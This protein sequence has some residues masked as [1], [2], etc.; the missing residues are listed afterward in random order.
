MRI[1]ITGAN[2]FVGSYIVSELLEIGYEV[3][4]SSRQG[5]SSSFGTKKNFRFVQVDI[6]DPYSLHDA[7]E[8]V[9]PDV[10]VHCAA[11]SKPDEC[12]INQAAAFDTNVF[13][14]VQ[15]LLNAEAYKSFFIHLSTDFIFNGKTGMHKEDDMPDPISYYGKTKLQAEEAVMEYEYDWAIVRT[16]FV[17]GKPIFGR[18][19]F[20]SMIEKKLRNNEPFK[21][22]NDQ[23]RT[24]T[25]ALDLA[26]GIATLIEKRATGVYHLCGKDVLSPYDMAI[27]TAKYLNIKEHQLTPVTTKA[28]QELA[29]RPLKSGLCIG[30][31]S[32]DLGFEPMSFKEGLKQTLD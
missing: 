1:L 29:E 27:A 3:F 24:P 20:I 9:K 18:D 31:A 23:E 6:T 7:F 5:D 4:A 22:V 30:K 11:M 28:L 17:Y 25:H 19:S 21:V 26:K 2:G 13:G 16:V 8:F 14:T 15:L 32:K 12:E 10:V